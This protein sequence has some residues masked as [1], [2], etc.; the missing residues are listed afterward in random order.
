MKEGKVSLLVVLLLGL[1]FVQF[2]GVSAATVYDKNAYEL[3]YAQQIPSGE[4]PNMVVTVLKYDSYPVVAGDW[5][6]LWVKVQNIGQKSANNLTITLKT[7]YPFSSND[8]LVKNYGILYGT[9]SAYKVDQTYDATQVVLKYRV[10]TEANAPTGVS[11]L[12]LVISPD[13]SNS[14]AASVEKDIPVEIFSPNK[15]PVEVQNSPVDN[16]TSLFYGVIGLI[17]GIFLVL[18]VGLLKN[19]RKKLRK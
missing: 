15:I 6:D 11:N 7:N 4:N 10:K 1:A 3:N 12:T 13:S 14:Y 8:T 5:F 19:K 2:A 17:S 9:L 16:S 18:L